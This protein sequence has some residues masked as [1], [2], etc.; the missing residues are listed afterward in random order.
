MRATEMRRPH[1]VRTCVFFLPFHQIT[2]KMSNDAPSNSFVLVCSIAAAAANQQQ[3]P[4]L[5]C[6]TLFITQCFI[7]LGHCATIQEDEKREE[8]KLLE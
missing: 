4:L 2:R 8:Q 1:I 5:C 3:T 7:I 6:T